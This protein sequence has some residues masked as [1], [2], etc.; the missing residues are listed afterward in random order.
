M[1][2]AEEEAER[3]PDE[4]DGLA[5]PSFRRDSKII[6]PFYHSVLLWLYRS[7]YVV[8]SGIDCIV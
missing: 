3:Q 2:A 5:S 1:V 8:I 6:V 7:P 4:T